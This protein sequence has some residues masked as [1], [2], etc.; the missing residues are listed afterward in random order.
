MPKRI[1]LI[2]LVDCSTSHTKSS[3]NQQ[4]KQLT[5]INLSISFKSN[6]T[7]WLEMLGLIKGT[8]QRFRAIENCE[9]RAEYNGGQ[10]SDL[11]NLSYNE[12]AEFCKQP[13]KIKVRV[14]R[15]RALRKTPIVGSKRLA[16]QR[17]RVNAEKNAMSS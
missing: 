7:L 4:K 10:I 11:W 12:M 6:L 9:F 17:E 13:G 8:Q 15:N 3:T 14:V 5:V 16:R 1:T 2:E